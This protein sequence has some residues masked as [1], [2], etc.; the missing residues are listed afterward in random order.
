MCR[1]WLW[2]KRLKRLSKNYLDVCR[3]IDRDK[4]DLINYLTV[5]CIYIV[6]K[7]IASQ[8]IEQTNS[9]KHLMQDNN[10]NLKISKCDAEIQY[11]EVDADSTLTSV[12]EEIDIEDGVSLI[13]STELESDGIK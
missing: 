13:K 12:S 5:P 2:R 11:E 10:D 3:A 4:F 6:E 9:Q 1:G 8:D 7:P